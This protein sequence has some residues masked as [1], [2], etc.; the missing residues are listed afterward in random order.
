[1]SK[2]QQ[3]A[4]EELSDVY[5]ID[6]D[7]KQISVDNVFREGDLCIEIGFGMGQA[8]AEIAEKLPYTNFIGIEVHRPGVGRL[9]SE[10]ERKGLKNIRIINHDAVEV[11][12]DMIGD[13][14]VSGFHIFFPDPWPKKKHHKRRLINDDFVKL[15]SRK[16][17]PGGYIYAVTDWE[18]YAE[19]MLRVLSGNKDLKNKYNTWAE[20]PGWRPQTSFER[21]GLEKQH[22]IRELY[23]NSVK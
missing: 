4:L 20:P 15:L 11:L 22:L 5:C 13:S 9:L 19:Q 12:E 6:Y 10:I 1:M 3:K 17:K 16:L 2:G 7:K 8:T 21:K 18:N 23:F 14:T